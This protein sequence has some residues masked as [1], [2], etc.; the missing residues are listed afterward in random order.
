MSA[1]IYLAV[2]CEVT[3]GP[4]YI[5][6][7]ILP[8]EPLHAEACGNEMLYLIL[9]TDEDKLFSQLHKHH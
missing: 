7:G 4:E 2:L 8:K 3:F 9:K 5:H 1:W 6:S